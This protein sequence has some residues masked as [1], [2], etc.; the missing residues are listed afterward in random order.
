MAVPALTWSAQ[1][2]LL[3]ARQGARLAMG[4][5]ATVPVLES[6]ELAYIE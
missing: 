6:A 5:G 1:D 2:C 4:F 3:Q